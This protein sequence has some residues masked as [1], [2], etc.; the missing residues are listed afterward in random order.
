MFIGSSYSMLLTVSHIPF[1]IATHIL[2]SLASPVLHPEATCYWKV[3]FS[4][5]G[6]QEVRLSL[7]P[8]LAGMF[9]GWRGRVGSVPVPDRWCEECVWR[10]LQRVQG[11]IPKVGTLHRCCPC[12]TA[13]IG[14]REVLYWHIWYDVWQMKIF[15]DNLAGRESIILKM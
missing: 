13:W 15:Q 11:G 3:T 8:R 5:R 9:Q 10:S 1:C 12:S 2:V 6:W 14:K 4:T 7:I